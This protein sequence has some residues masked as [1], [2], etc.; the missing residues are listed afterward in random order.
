MIS[1]GRAGAVSRRAFMR[2]HTWARGML[3]QRQKTTSASKKKCEHVLHRNL[4]DVWKRLSSR[5][6]EKTRFEIAVKHVVISDIDQV[7]DHLAKVKSQKLRSPR[8]LDE[9]YLE[10]TTA[11]IDGNTS[12][13]KASMLSL[14]LDP[15]HHFFD[16][17]MRLPSGNYKW[18]N[19]KEYLTSGSKPPCAGKTPNPNS[20]KPLCFNYPKRIIPIERIWTKMRRLYP[21]LFMRKPTVKCY[22]RGVVCMMKQSGMYEIIFVL[23]RRYKG[24]TI[25]VYQVNI[26]RNPRDERIFHYTFDAVSGRLLD[27][28]T[29]PRLV[30]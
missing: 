22:T 18:L 7:C 29:S 16:W 19:F 25:P 30:R 23:K 9:Y 8:M 21:S 5:N 20:F 13:L 11:S 27:K 28:Y 14:G 6:H 12:K 10:C 2:I 4:W 17:R 15:K 1:G 26:Y 24:R 3:C